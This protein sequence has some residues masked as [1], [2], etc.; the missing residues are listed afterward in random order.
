MGQ[1]NDRMSEIDSRV[2]ELASLEESNKKAEEARAMFES[3]P[4]IEILLKL[5]TD[6]QILRAFVNGEVRSQL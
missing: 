6:G 2:N 3:K 1:M 5:K 4:V